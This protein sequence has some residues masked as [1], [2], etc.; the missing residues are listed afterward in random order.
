MTTPLLPIL[1]GERAP[2][3]FHENIQHIG[4]QLVGRLYGVIQS[5]RA[6]LYQKGLLSAYTAP[7]PVISVGN[8]TVG[9]TGKTPTVIWLAKYF[10]SKGR[11]VGVVSRGYRQQSKADVTVVS[12][13]HKI[14]TTTPKAADEAVLI[15]QTLPGVTVITGPKRYKTIAVAT[16]Q[17]GC[18]LIIMDDAFQHMQVKRDLDLVLLDCNAPFSNGHILPGGL[19]REYP[20][21]LHRCDGVIITRANDSKKLKHTQ[22]LLSQ[23][24]PNKKSCSA[25][26]KPTHW[27][28]LSQTDPKHKETMPIDGFKDIAVLAFCGIAKPDNFYATL[29]TLAISVVASQSYS[30]HHVFDCN[31][32]DKLLEK[33]V[34]LKAQALLC[35]EKDAVKIQKISSDLPIYALSMELYFHNISPWLQKQLDSI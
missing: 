7:C 11:K 23:I 4:L 12:D 18:N 14:I 32:I 16:Q 22:N 27:R 19:L 15:A 25:L 3:G 10:Q 13:P 21:A 20:S 31:T 2:Q 29:D 33:A 6:A 34:T 28:K 9:G 26:H 24:V 35:T 1:A 8:I 5:I 17:F 30:D